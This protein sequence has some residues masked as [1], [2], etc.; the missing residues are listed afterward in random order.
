MDFANFFASPFFCVIFMMEN[1]HDSRM[2]N[3]DVIKK[4][5]NFEM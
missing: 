4:D 1:L 3:E 5:V 2:K